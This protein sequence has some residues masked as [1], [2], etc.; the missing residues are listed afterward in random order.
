MREARVPDRV[1]DTAPVPGT[2]SW[3]RKTKFLPSWGSHAAKEKIILTLVQ[4]VGKTLFK[5]IA[6]YVKTLETL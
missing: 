3:D 2:H 6:I 4:T 1:P 5:T